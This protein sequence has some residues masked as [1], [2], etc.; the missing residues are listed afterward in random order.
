MRLN[1]SLITAGIILVVLCSVEP[2]AS[3]DI[4]SRDPCADA[5]VVDAATGIVRGHIFS[6]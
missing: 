5:I 4:V 3:M 6:C 1:I 2:A